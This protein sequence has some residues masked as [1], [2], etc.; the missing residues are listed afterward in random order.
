MLLQAESFIVQRGAGK[1]KSRKVRVLHYIY[2][3]LR[4]IEESTHIYTGNTQAAPPSLE[5]ENMLYP[6]LRTHSLR[7][8]KDMDALCGGNFES[9]LFGDCSNIQKDEFAEIYGFPQQLVSFISRTTYLSNA[10]SAPSTSLDQQCRQLETGICEWTSPEQTATNADDP[11]SLL[12]NQIMMPHLISAIHSAI[13]IFF[14]RRIRNVHPLM[15]QH[16]AEKTISSLEKFETEKRSLC[17]TNC[18]IVWPGFMAASEALDEGL[19]ERSRVLLRGCARATGMRNFDVA[20]DVVESVWAM[21]RNV[22]LRVDWSCVVRPA[23]VLT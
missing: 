7:L 16:H 14:Y 5:P 20:C 2:L 9:L 22:G 23:L 13:I 21:K 4:V 6:S 17:L 3:Y 1:A 19:R 10:T 15:L 18:G 8:G 12:A 11:F